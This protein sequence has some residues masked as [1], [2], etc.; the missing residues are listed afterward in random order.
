MSPTVSTSRTQ[1][2]PHLTL[3]PH[4]AD[5]RLRT[6]RPRVQHHLGG[7][8]GRHAGRQRP[9]G[10]G[11][12]RAPAR[13]PLHRQPARVLLVRVACD[14]AGTGAEDLWWLR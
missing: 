4:S 9:P 12:Q 1:L 11:G 8:G 5:E 10:R 6:E 3:I 2:T 14:G 13:E 7:S